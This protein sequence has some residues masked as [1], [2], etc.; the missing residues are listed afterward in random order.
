MM[1]I[2]AGS[3]YIETLFYKNVCAGGLYGLGDEVMNQYRRIRFCGLP[4][5]YCHHVGF[6]LSTFCLKQ[7]V[8]K[9]SR[10]AQGA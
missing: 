3:W 5:F 4:I 6:L 10:A 8:A 1:T 9:N 2:N 7:K